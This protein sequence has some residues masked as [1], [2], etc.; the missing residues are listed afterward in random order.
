MNTAFYILSFLTVF[1]VLLMI[2]QKNPVG[3][4][5]SLVLSF[6]SLAGLYVLLE[7]HFVAAVQILVYAGAIM[8][9]FIF[10]IMLLNL[11]NDE[12]VHDKL[13]FKRMTVFLIGMALFVF[14]ALRFA[15][16]PAGAFTELSPDFGTAKAVAKLMFTTYVVPFEVIGVLLLVGIVGAIVLGGRE[17]ES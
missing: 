13:N 14:L 9:L 6:F 7:A 8:V 3:S 11:K 4:A 16:I 12:L 10:V 15:K 17:D 2:L 5:L 1:F